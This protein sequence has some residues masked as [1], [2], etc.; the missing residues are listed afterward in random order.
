MITLANLTRERRALALLIL[1]FYTTIFTLAAINLGGAWF[2]CF[3]GLGLVYGLAFFSLAAR[4]FWA[5]WYAMGLGV[6]GITMAAI[7]IVQLG[8]DPGILI[9]GGL[10]LIIYLPL[11]GEA[12][13][14]MYEGQPAWRERFGMDEHGVHRLKR[15]VGSAATGL[16]T[17]VM[18]ALAPRQGSM[19]PLLVLLLAGLGLYGLI[20]LRFWGVAVLGLGGLYLFGVM[21]LFTPVQ[22]SLSAGVSFHQTLGLAAGCFLVLSVAPFAGPAYRFLREG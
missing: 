22:S 14:E 5:R 21:A 12:M 16:P 1:G 11:A 8:L 3:L 15:A 6:S 7:G 9:W 10:H 18:Y 19:A 20:R 2:R 13:A 4:W 17:L